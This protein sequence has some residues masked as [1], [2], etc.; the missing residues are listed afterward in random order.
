MTPFAAFVNRWLCEPAQ[1]GESDCCLT[2]L[3]WAGQV[4]GRDLIGDLRFAYDD[5]ASAQKVTR[6]FS[7]P[8]QIAA[9]VLEAGAGFERTSR[10]VRGDVAVWRWASHGGRVLP[11]GGICAAPGQFVARAAPGDRPGI[12]GCKSPEI[13]GA[14]SVGYCDD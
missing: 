10:P 1:W 13:L 4:A 14:W 7:D 8:L 11:V 3:D 2:A 9:R 5:F 6:F 12:I